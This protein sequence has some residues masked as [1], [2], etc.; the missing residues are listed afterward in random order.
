MKRI[1]FLLFSWIFLTASTTVQGSGVSS[2]ADFE[3]VDN[4][5]VKYNGAGGHVVIPDGVTSIGQSA[6]SGCDGLISVEIPNSVISIGQSAFDLCSNLKSVTVNWITPISYPYGAFGPLN[7]SA[8]SLYVPD[9]AKAS[10]KMAS[11]WSNFGKVIQ[12]S[13]FLDFEIVDDVLIGYRGAGGRVIIP[14]VTSIGPRAFQ[15]CSSLT[16]IEIFNTVTRIEESAFSGCSGLIS[17]LF[18]G[19]EKVTQDTEVDMNSSEY[20]GSMYNEASSTNMN[21]RAGESFD[22]N[23]YSLTSIGDRAFDGCINLVFTMT[24]IYMGDDMPDVPHIPAEPHIVI[25]SSIISI[26]E[27]AFRN[28]SSMTG[29]RMSKSVTSIGASAFSGCSS[30][31]TVAISDSVKSIGDWA[32]SGC[33]HLVSMRKGYSRSPS[34]YAGE[35]QPSLAVL[36]PPSATSIGQYAFQDCS[37]ITSIVMPNTV[38]DVGAHAFMNCSGLKNV[39][40]KWIT[41]LSVSADVFENLNLSGLYLY[42]PDGVNATY[43]EAPVWKDFRM[44]VEM[45]EASENSDF[46]IVNGVLVRY[47]GTGGRVFI[48]NGVTGV[49]NR[50]FINCTGLTSVEIPPSVT[51]VGDSA[52]YGCPSLASIE[53]PVSV[54]DIGKNAFS[55]CIHLSAINIDPANSNYASED[56]V[57]YNKN[58]TTLLVYPLG[59]GSA[60]LIPNSVT[61]IGDSAFYDCIKLVSVEIPNTVKNIGTSAF[62]GCIGL[63]SIEI[64][65]SVVSIGDFA[66]A[67]CSGLRNVFVNRATPVL[68]G[69]SVSYI[70]GSAFY[71]GINPQNLT[72]YVPSGAKAAY[73]A[74]PVWQDFGTIMEAGEVLG[75][76]DFEIV[77]GVLVRYRGGGG[78]QVVI[79]AEVTGIGNRAFVNCIGLTSVEIPGLV[80]NIGDSAFYGC[81]GLTSIEIPSPVVSIGTGA[82]GRC[83][84]LV[85][86]EIASSVASIGESAFEDCISLASVEIPASV[87]SIGAG[88]FG[89][90]SSLYAIET[91]AANGYYLSEDGVLYNKDKTELHTFPAGRGGDFSIPGTVTGVGAYAFSGGRGLRS[92]EIPG[93]VA[94]LGYNAFARC[95]GLKDV[96]G[97]G[98]C[99]CCRRRMLL[100]AQ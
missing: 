6:F 63:T 47:R 25:P 87:E 34:T 2:S 65:G 66:F 97:N 26:G 49:G 14:D 31:E 60:F 79:P 4:V 82:F 28:C 73:Q 84:S 74:A 38:T 20:G 83:I 80:T 85:S 91:D 13:D 99:R 86:V 61:N 98:Q 27:S 50:A 53:I 95:S 9:G 96:T 1:A 59:K 78:G 71:N 68:L 10:Y 93:S 5:L 81:I 36:I 43:R 35:I 12:A 23:S 69:G 16:S 70:G 72:L 67:Y 22:E 89:G 11:G 42:V 39:T 41:P 100:P 46:E 94:S 29:V 88:A 32:F 40:V 77:N 15:D 17:I 92:V 54:A 55:G 8:S 44:I 33:T 21:T 37:G 57:L 76:S 7:L 64:P 30:L 19:S 45:G 48:P 90:C 51:N 24:G 52:L 75:N 3:I 56:G 62:S 18:F 58:K